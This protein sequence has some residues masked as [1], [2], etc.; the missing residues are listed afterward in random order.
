MRQGRFRERSQGGQFT[1]GFVPHREGR[2]VQIGYEFPQTV[3]THRHGLQPLA[4]HGE[5]D[6]RC[7]GG[8]RPHHERFVPRPTA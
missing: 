3:R 5:H 2:V 4:Q 6:R 1:P 8:G 7:I